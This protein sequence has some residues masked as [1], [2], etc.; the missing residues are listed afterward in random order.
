MGGMKRRATILGTMAVLALATTGT[1][2]ATAY[3][4]PIDAPTISAET[5]AEDVTVLAC[6][7]CQ[8]LS[9]AGEPDVPWKVMTVLLPPDA[10]LGTVSVFLEDVQVEM[11]PGAGTIRPAPPER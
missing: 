5:D 9:R 4:I 11:I 1:A 3:R 6:P 10:A 7:G 2:A 8:R